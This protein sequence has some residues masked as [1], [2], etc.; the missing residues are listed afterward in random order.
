MAVTVQSN[1]KEIVAGMRGKA[2]LAVRKAAKDVQG[3]AKGG[4]AV[5]TGFMRSNIR[6]MAQGKYASEVI[7]HAEYSVY[8]EYGTYK[9]GAQ[10]FMVPAAEAV[11][12]SFIAAMRQVV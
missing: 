2:T 8:V 9:M 4:A 7:S 5:D 6:T 12:P 1:I 10:P 11:R 3:Q